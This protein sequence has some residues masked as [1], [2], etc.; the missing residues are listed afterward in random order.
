MKVL[1]FHYVRPLPDVHYPE[2]KSP[3]FTEL[4]ASS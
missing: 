1:V 3:S 2:L 4:L